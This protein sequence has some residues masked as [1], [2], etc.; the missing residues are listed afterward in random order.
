VKKKKIAVFTGGW[1][2]EYMS[3]ILSGIIDNIE[4]ES[5]D[6][7]CFV[8]FSIAGGLPEL[9]KAQLNFYR[10][11]DITKFDAVVLLTN[12][13]NQQEEI[14][15]LTDEIRKANIPAL[16]VEYQLDGITSIIS[17]N[18]SGM[19]ALSEHIIT[20]H[21]AKNIVCIAGPLG[22]SESNIRVD[23]LKDAMQKHSLIL[24]E[25]NLIHGNWG[26]DL[27][28]GQID[29]WLAENNNE[30][31]D[32]FVCANDIMAIA[33]CD[34][35]RNIGYSVPENVIVTGYDCI[36]LAQHY[37]PP[38]TSVNH[39]WF[40]MGQHTSLMIKKL[41][42]RE[43]VPSLLSLKTSLVI[44]G[45]CGCDKGNGFNRNKKYLGRALVKNEMD[46]MR[47]D[48]H[49][50]HF[51]STVR[52]VTDRIGLHWSLS[53]LFEHGH[54]IEGEEFG[55]F[56]YPEFFEEDFDSKI[57]EPFNNA[58]CV[59]ICSLEKGKA[60]PVDTVSFED[61][62]F[63]AANA[64]EEFGYYIFVPLY[65]GGKTF[66]YAR[67]TGPLNAAS[68]NQYYIWSMHMT[69]A[70]E[71]VAANFTIQNLYSKLEKLSVTDSLT[72][73]YNRAGC[74]KISYPKMIEWA[75]EGASSVVMLVDV[76][77]MKYINDSFGHSNGDKALK[78]VAGSLKEALP[79]HFIISRFGGDEFFVAGRLSS[80]NED[81]ETLV[82]KIEETILIRSREEKTEFD[83]T[84]SIGYVVVEP[85]NISDIEHAVVRADECMYKHKKLHHKIICE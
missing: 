62:V 20:S 11:P 34:H 51:Y 54:T 21:K 47:V 55:L 78:L 14:D 13:F 7:F 2:G 73:I 28:P 5:Y 19:Y 24:K 79:E 75:A 65:S 63:G 8:N 22:H 61:A 82:H 81:L 53:Y 30:L 68:D 77:R 66:G 58:D 50:R 67:L 83:L 4:K 64:K 10:L 60:L 40:T 56:I 38:I 36:S 16:S 9:N 6:V 18:Y 57:V 35:L 80:P 33:V 15:Y 31:P 72:D 43:D 48:S 29:D 69:Q 42:K 52:K 23:A 46:P 27:I 37:N 45:S 12:S 25:E 44:G 26:N 70:L 74:E 84:A 3:E 1:S 49:F 17:D 76:D 39:E 32:A 71:Q 85:K 59:R 41:I